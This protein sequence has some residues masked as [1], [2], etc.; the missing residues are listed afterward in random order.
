[1]Q[2]L[3][4]FSSHWIFALVV[5]SVLTHTTNMCAAFKQSVS[6]NSQVTQQHMLNCIWVMSEKVNVS[7]RNQVNWLQLFPA[8]IA[9]FFQLF[10]EA[11]PN[12]LYVPHTGWWRGV[13]E[14]ILLYHHVYTCQ[15]CANACLL[16]VFYCNSYLC[17]SASSNNTLQWVNWPQWVVSSDPQAN[18]ELKQLSASPV[19]RCRVTCGCMGVCEGDEGIWSLVSF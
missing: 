17:V 11:T 13:Q 3:L 4:F 9:D 5:A 19:E 15:L 8:L 6:L 18:S 2:G 1:M 14:F 7:C 16:S 12:Q 10:L